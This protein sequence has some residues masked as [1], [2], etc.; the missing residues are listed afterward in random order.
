MDTCVICGKYVP[1]GSQV[2]KECQNNP[3]INIKKR[4][5][6]L[7]GPSGSGKSTFARDILIN[8]KDDVIISRDDIRFSLL[9]EKDSYFDKETIVFE[10]FIKSIQA[11]LD[12]ET[13]VVVADAM[14]LTEKARNKVL[15]KLNWKGYELIAVNFRTPLNVCLERNEARSGLKKVPRGQVR[16]HYFSFVPATQNE[17]YKYDVIIDV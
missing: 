5:Y 12:K 3:I 15:D 7:C 9:E 6:L 1:E 11:A 2:C 10:K 17:K 16:R 14:H 8:S 4:F 13:S